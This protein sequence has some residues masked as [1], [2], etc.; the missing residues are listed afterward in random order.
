VPGAILLQITD[1]GTGIDPAFLPFVF[2]PF[3]Q[4]DSAVRGTKGGL[5]LGMFIARGLAE[6]HHGTLTVTSEGCNLGSTFHLRLPASTE[7][8][9]PH[10]G[11]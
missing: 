7:A 5:G 1:V 9:R 2:D 8:S 6:A 3:K 11:R 10:A 4:S